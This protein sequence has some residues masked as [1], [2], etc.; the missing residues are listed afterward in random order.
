MT[1]WHGLWAK[2]APPVATGVVGVAAYEALTK[3]PWRSA[4][5]TATAWS[6]RTARETERRTKAA[7]ER[8][9]LAAADVLAEA[10]ERVGE[11][12]PPPPATAATPTIVAEADNASH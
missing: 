5:V 3:A 4:T 9:R 1:F 12:V 10:A 7:A 8:I 6:L 2:A 11:E